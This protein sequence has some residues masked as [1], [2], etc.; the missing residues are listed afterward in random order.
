[1]SAW[2]FIVNAITR[3]AITGWILFIAKFSKGTNSFQVTSSGSLTGLIR[4][5]PLMSYG[6][7]ARRKPLKSVREVGA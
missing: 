2:A 4:K 6:F 5:G 3:K 7:R 1:M